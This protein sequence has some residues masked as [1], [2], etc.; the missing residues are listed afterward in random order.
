MKITDIV[1]KTAAKLTEQ[2]I[3][4]V[5]ASL[6]LKPAHIKA[7]LSVESKGHGFFDDNRPIILF[8]AH[9]FARETKQQ[10]NKSHPNISSPKWDKTLYFGGKK[11]YTRLAEAMNLDSAAALKSASY[12]LFQILGNNFKMCGC[13]CVEEFVQKMCKDERSQLELF[14]KFIEKTGILAKLKA[15]DW[16]GVA[17]AYNGPS[18]SSNNYAEK[19][20]KAFANSNP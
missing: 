16:A 10:Y 1:S 19:L 2:D 4:D 20:E 12:G 13:A 5:A 3:A 11:E 14:A 15:C 9:L 8:E 18:A 17:R 6:G 7:V